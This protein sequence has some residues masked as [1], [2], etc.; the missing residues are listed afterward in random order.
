[1]LSKDYTF[2]SERLSYRGIKRDD[3]SDIV[4][5]RSDPSTF[6]FFFRARAITLESHLI[7]FDEYLE[8]P[9]RF[10]FLA[11]LNDGTPVG[12]V[13]LSN[14][15]EDSCE[16]SYMVGEPSLRGRGLGREM[17]E[18]AS[19]LAFRELGVKTIEARIKPDNPAS[20]ATARAAGYRE[21]ECVYRKSAFEDVP[22]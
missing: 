12:T 19:A 1:M 21:E 17:L 6:R 3:A 2:S 8:D 4:R 14:I 18:A 11:L 20:I 10:D 9:S 22:A 13:G 5:W 16:V 7:W 15:T